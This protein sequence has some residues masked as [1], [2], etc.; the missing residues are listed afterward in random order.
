[1][2]FSARSVHMLCGLF[3]SMS[4]AAIFRSIFQVC[5]FISVAA[6]D[7]SLPAYFSIWVSNQTWPIPGVAGT[8]SALGSGLGRWNLVFMNESRSGISCGP[9]PSE[10]RIGAGA[11]LGSQVLSSV[12]LKVCQFFG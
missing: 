11:K 1:M 12:A 8:M 9:L 2:T 5:A 4:G 3:I 6:P 7:L 10:V